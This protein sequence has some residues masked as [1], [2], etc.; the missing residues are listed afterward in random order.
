MSR[1]D[2]DFFH[3]ILTVSIKLPKIYKP[4]I[5][6]PLFYLYDIDYFLIA[7]SDTVFFSVDFD[8]LFLRLPY[9]SNIPYILLDSFLYKL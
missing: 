1:V 8:N 3:A 9:D 4:V 6:F 2:F 7:Q 5:L